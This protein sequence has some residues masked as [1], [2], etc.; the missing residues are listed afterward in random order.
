M[1]KV[2]GIRSYCLSEK[3]ILHDFFFFTG[4]LG[5]GRITSCIENDYIF[6]M[7]GGFLL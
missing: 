5:L 7:N 2:A 1:D 4:G 6:I 3:N